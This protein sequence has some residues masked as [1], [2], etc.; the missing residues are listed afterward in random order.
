MESVYKPRHDEKRS[1]SLPEGYAQRLSSLAFPYRVVPGIDWDGCFNLDSFHKW[2]DDVL[3]W[4]KKTDRLETVLQTIGNGLSYAEKNEGLPNDTILD[5]LNKPQNRQMRIGYQLGVQNRSLF[6]WIDPEGKTE[7]TMA[8][9]YKNYAQKAEERG[10]SRVAEM[11]DSIA[12]YFQKEAEE[13][14]KMMRTRDTE[15]L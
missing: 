7:Q 4:A 9:E 11:L 1:S 3:S 10:Y 12:T 13:N 5:E 8:Q 15:E 2:I 6:H 14:K